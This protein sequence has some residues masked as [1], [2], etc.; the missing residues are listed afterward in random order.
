MKLNISTSIPSSSRVHIAT[1]DARHANASEPTLKIVKAPSPFKR[2]LLNIITFG[3]HT[4]HNVN[5]RE[6]QAFK[7]AI[8]ADLV[9]GSEHQLTREDALAKADLAL[10]GFNPHKRLTLA[11]INTALADVENLKAGGTLEARKADRLNSSQTMAIRAIQTVYQINRAH[12]R[13]EIELENKAN[14]LLALQKKQ[15]PEFS[16][17]KVNLREDIVKSSNHSSGDDDDFEMIS[18]ATVPDKAPIVKTLH[19]S[20]EDLDDYEMI[21]PETVPDNAPAQAFTETQADWSKSI[22]KVLQPGRSFGSEPSNHGL[23]ALAIYA[24]ERGHN[25]AYVSSTIIP[26]GFAG[27][28]VHDMVD[29]AIA[30]HQSHPRPEALDAQGTQIL[31]MPLALQSRK[32]GAEDHFVL[33][34]VDYRNRKVLYLDPKGHSIEKGTKTYS[35]AEGLKAELGRLGNAVF[36]DEWDSESGIAQMTQAKQQGANDCGSLV[37]GFT[38][39]LIDG[40]SLGDIERTFTSSD[41][42]A[43]RLEMAQDIQRYLVEPATRQNAES[44]ANR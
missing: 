32:R 44:A 41:R 33:V 10:S 4:K 40:Q 28:P 29:Q 9:H 22:L 3:Y 5:P 25:F 42:R 27:E 11:K 20:Q 18:P 35:N 16:T 2:G 37:H 43:V 1:E 38:R 39:R 24:K 26:K 17:S 34:A 15:R 19:K 14:D 7:N 23:E 36:G 30:Q 21:S 13:Q 6:W 31:A 8:A 12:T